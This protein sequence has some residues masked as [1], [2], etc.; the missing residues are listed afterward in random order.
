MKEHI[1]VEQF[2]DSVIDDTIHDQD[3]FSTKYG[4]TGK[5]YDNE[6]D[7]IYTPEFLQFEKELIE[8]KKKKELAS[9]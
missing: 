7:G 9:F 2:I 5:I 8:R 3:N 1:L 4:F 6:E